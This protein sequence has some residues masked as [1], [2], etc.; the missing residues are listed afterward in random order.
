MKRTVN[1]TPL[2]PKSE[3]RRVRFLDLEDHQPFSDFT[4]SLVKTAKELSV[5]PLLLDKEFSIA[6]DEEEIVTTQE[7]ENPFTVS[8]ESEDSWSLLERVVQLKPR[9]EEAAAA[10]SSTVEVEATKGTDQSES[11][12]TANI[13]KKEFGKSNAPSEADSNRSESN[14]IGLSD[15]IVADA[16]NSDGSDSDS[17]SSSSSDSDDNSDDEEVESGILALVRDRDNSIAQKIKQDT[18]EQ[19]LRP[20]N[21]QQTVTQPYHVAAG[22]KSPP[23][24]RSSSTVVSVTSGVWKINA[25]PSKRPRQAKENLGWKERP[26]DRSSRKRSATASSPWVIN[27]FSPEH[28]GPSI[29]SSKKSSKTTLPTQLR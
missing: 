12:Q 13:C 2:T 6:S 28:R 1:N 8:D 24:P 23:S 17:S 19:A 22:T 15:N 26:I 4:R 18:A 10:D 29:T 3:A 25:M 21:K 11:V 14:D 20:S 16:T 27:R 5:Q 7:Q 9:D